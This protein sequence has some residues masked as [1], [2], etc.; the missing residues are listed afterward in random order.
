M[1][2]APLTVN[3]VPAAEVRHSRLGVASFTVSVAV[4][5]AFLV[6]FGIHVLRE[7]ASPEPRQTLEGLIIIGLWAADVL[8]VGLGVAGVFQSGVKKAFAIL[9]TVFSALTIVG[10][11]CICAIGHESNSQNCTCQDCLCPET[12]AC[13]CSR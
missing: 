2:D 6:L 12:T 10:I 4:G 11:I 13:D 5:L 8:A 1:I 3:P 9:G 7:P